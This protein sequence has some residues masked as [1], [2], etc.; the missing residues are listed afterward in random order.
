MPVIAGAVPQVIRGH[1]RITVNIESGIMRD[2][3][4]GQWLFVTNYQTVIARQRNG[5]IAVRAF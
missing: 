5:Q 4:D 1:R 3:A 2:V